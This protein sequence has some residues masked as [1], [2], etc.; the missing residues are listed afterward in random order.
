MNYGVYSRSAKMTMLHPYAGT[1]RKC[2][3]PF[4][5]SGLPGYA[6]SRIDEAFVLTGT[7]EMLLFDPRYLTI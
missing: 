4:W 7:F 1:Y 2:L 3:Y 6:I 5:G